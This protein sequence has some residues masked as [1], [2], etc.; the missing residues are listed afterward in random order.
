MFLDKLYFFCRAAAKKLAWRPKIRLK[1]DFQAV[2][3]KFSF[4]AGINKTRGR[5]GH[6][7]EKGFLSKIFSPG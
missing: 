5:E 2:E 3:M 1:F 4:I 7:L 6:A